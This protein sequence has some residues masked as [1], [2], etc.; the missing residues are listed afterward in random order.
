MVAYLIMSV[1]GGVIGA[2]F[3]QIVEKFNHHRA[4]HINPYGWRR[5]FEV[6][7]ITL[8]T[9]TVVIFLPMS[10]T[11][12]ILTREI[13]LEDSGGCFPDK[14]LFQVTYGTT[15]YS[16]LERLVSAAG[17]GTVANSSFAA[18]APASNGGSG[19]GGEEGKG[20]RRAADTSETNK[21]RSSNFMDEKNYAD[22]VRGAYY[23]DTSRSRTSAAESSAAESSAAESSEVPNVKR[24][25]LS[26]DEDG[27]MKVLP[28]ERRQH[29]RH[30]SSTDEEAAERRILASVAKDPQNDEEGTDYYGADVGPGQTSEEMLASLKDHLANHRVVES[31]RDYKE[32]DVLMIDNIA[33]HGPY[34][35]IHYEHTYTCGKA[36]H[37]YNDMAMLWLNGGAKGVKTLM[38]RGFPHQI[39]EQ[40]L[41]VFL[42]VYFLLAAITSGTHVPA[43]LV[44]PMLLIGGSFGRLFGLLWLKIKA[45]MCENYEVLGKFF[46]FFFFFFV[47]FFVFFFFF[48]FFFFF[49]SLFLFLFVSFFLSFF[50]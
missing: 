26:V 12:R 37:S 2:A 36:S 28:P 13:M 4:H 7:F 34:I 29:L 14:D 18:A 38:Q 43:G 25:L 24:L 35:H 33:E 49:V 20:R 39:S 50:F 45:G 44:V 11:C 27:E 46:F 47:F 9:G 32:Y 5:L 19:G 3:N 21:Q 17:N 1:I 31:H 15:S 41:A 8:L 42:V 23:K 22:D 6:L 48:F 40:T 16:F 10:G 30:L